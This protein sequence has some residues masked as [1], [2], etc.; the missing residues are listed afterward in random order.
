M[1]DVDISPK[2]IR[3]SFFS[4]PGISQP[5]PA[6]LSPA[7]VTL[8]LLGP[9]PKFKALKPKENLKAFVDTEGLSPGRHRLKVQVQVPPGLTLEKV[10]PSTL[11]ARLKK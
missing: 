2:T 11:T 8:T 10:S 7:K 3:R 9:W 4:I 1:A 6:Q 5:L